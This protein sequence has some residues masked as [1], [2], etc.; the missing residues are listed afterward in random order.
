MILNKSASKEWNKN[1]GKKFKNEKVGS[2][3]GCFN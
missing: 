3:Y 2:C 1:E